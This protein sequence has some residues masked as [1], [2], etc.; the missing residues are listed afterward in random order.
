MAEKV[1]KSG[2]SKKQ[3]KSLKEKRAAKNMKKVE[4]GSAR[5]A[6]G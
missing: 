1:A 4:R 2:K 5:P 3:G 6:G